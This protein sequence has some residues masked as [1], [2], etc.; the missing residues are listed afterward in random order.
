MI[1]ND[2]IAINFN[3]KYV[4]DNILGV[5]KYGRD[6]LTIL[7]EIIENYDTLDE[8][9]QNKQIV[10]KFFYVKRALRCTDNELVEQIKNDS[11]KLR[12]YEYL[13]KMIG[14]EDKKPYSKKTIELLL[15]YD[16]VKM[17]KK[18]DWNME[19]ITRV[20]VDHKKEI[21]Q[22]LHLYTGECEGKDDR[23]KPTDE[24]SQGIFKRLYENK[25]NS[26]ATVNFINEFLQSDKKDYDCEVF[27]NDKPII[28][29][30]SEIEAL[31]QAK[32][33]YRVNEKDGRRVLRLLCILLAWQKAYENKYLNHRFKP[34]AELRTDEIIKYNPIVEVDGRLD[35]VAL[36]S[37]RKK[38]DEDGYI[39]KMLPMTYAPREVPA[40]CYYSLSFF[41]DGESGKDEEVAL[42]ITDYENMWEQ[43]FVA[44]FKEFDVLEIPKEK[45][46]KQ[47]EIKEYD[48]KNK[49]G[50]VYVLNKDKTYSFDATGNYKIGDIVNVYIIDSKKGKIKIL[51]KPNERVY[52]TYKAVKR[53]SKCGRIFYAKQMGNGTGQCDKCNRR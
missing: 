46:I 30:E 38:L 24:K 37:D 3:D 33:K 52:V 17:T 35:A 10:E 14:S 11:I 41:V 1:S 15:R 13:K 19:D 40:D 32:K 45:D 7:K 18:S 28:I 20:F 51:K 29:Y 23:G 34:Y 27:F 22:R 16:I 31:K 43:I 26:N 47:G 8:E 21:M 44:A 12:L 36:I 48:K 2:L 6:N 53:C 4:C 5:Y 50:K 39:K 9:E 42:T 25:E 49:Y